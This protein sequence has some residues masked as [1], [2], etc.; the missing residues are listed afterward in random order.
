MGEA[1]VIKGGVP[2]KGEI[3]ISGA[4]N[5]TLPLMAA[6][7]LTDQSLTLKNVP[8]LADVRTMAMV[9]ETLGS[10]ITF[11]NN[12]MQI[13]NPQ[14][15][16][17]TAPYDLVK[18]MRA[19]IL[20]LGPLVAKYGHAKVSLPGGCAIGARAVDLHLEGLKCLGASVELD[21][22]YITAKAPK[23]GLV[24]NTV[25]LKMPSVGATENIM[26]AASLAQ[27]ETTIKNA[28]R[29][30]EIIDLGNCLN[31]MGANIFGLGS[32]TITIQGV[33]TLKPAIHKVVADRIETGT[34]AIAALIT[35]GDLVLRNTTLE[36]LPVFFQ[37]LENAGAKITP[38]A[39]SV[40]ITASD[41]IHG[42]DIMTEPYPGFPTDLQAQFMALMS[43]CDG[44]AMITETIFENRFMHVPEL[45]RMGAD[46]KV[47]QSSALVRGVNK[48]NGAEVMATDLRASVSLVLAGLV[49]EGET[50]V[51]RIYHLD[52]G[53]ENLTEKLMGC[54]A[55]IQR[56]KS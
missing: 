56:I 51:G 23:D 18:T 53:Y 5:A 34:Y 27:G 41:K 16:Q 49:A 13:N 43:I 9:L 7:L 14:I 48:L 21:Q 3:Q 17:T 26:M 50:K 29:E 20:V 54:G 15:N 45:C 33:K 55:N 19:S 47:H 10:H 1:L 11:A 39:D 38:T 46:I 12:V 2:L 25:F 40:Q 31:A 8:N 24:G 44:A 30:P 35:K 52:R 37:A 36:N 22:G 6:S 4:K 28:A 32:D 42:V